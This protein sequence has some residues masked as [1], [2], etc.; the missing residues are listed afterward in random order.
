MSVVTI[1]GTTIK[2]WCLVRGSSPFKVVIGQD[3]DI[4][5][6]KKIIKEER[7][8]RF[9][10]F[11]PDELILWTVDIDQSQIEEIDIDDMLTGERKLKNSALPVGEVFDNVNGNN[12][13][14]FVEVPGK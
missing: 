8:P 1:S 5:D 11:A 12:V 7:K 9:N 2:L 14:V 3:N 10:D 4:D 6:L 13:R